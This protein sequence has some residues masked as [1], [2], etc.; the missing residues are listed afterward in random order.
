MNSAF[1]KVLYFR[2]RATAFTLIELLVVIAIIALLAS[3]LLPALSKAKSQ[4]YRIKCLNNLRQLGTIWVCTPLTTMIE[5]FPMAEENDRRG[6]PTWVSG[7]FQE[8]PDDTT[9]ALI[10]VDP[11]RSLFA[12]YLTA[13]SLYKCPADKSVKIPGRNSRRSQL[14]HECLCGLA[15]SQYRS[16]RTPTIFGCSPNQR[17]SRESHR[18]ICWF[19]RRLMGR[20]IAAHSS[21]LHG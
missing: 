10:M 4:A 7:S 1:G 17:I 8:V 19:F 20:A 9:N 11:K 2:R 18:G 3:L 14:W 6:G 16:L 12:A 5:S 15:E 13:T 21:A